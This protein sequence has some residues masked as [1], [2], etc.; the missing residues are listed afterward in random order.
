LA[1]APV[2]ALRR[3]GGIG[4][5]VATYFVGKE[6]FHARVGLL[7]AVILATSARV[8]W[9]SRWAHLDMPLSLFVT[10]ALLFFWRGMT[11][12]GSGRPFY[13]A[14]AF[15]A[16]ATLTKGLI[17]IVLPG[18]VLVA[19]VALRREWSSLLSWRIPSGALVFLAIA[20]PWFAWVSAQTE[21]RWL[22]E[23]IWVH[24]LER[25]TAS[26]GH[27]EPFYY[28]L[29][30]LPADFLPWSLFALPALWAYRSRLERLR[31]PGRLF[32]FLWAAVIFLFFS[33]SDSKRGLYLLPLFPPVAI[34][35]ACFFEELIERTLSLN[36]FGR[37]LALVFFGLL[38]VFAVASPVV[39]W[40]FARELFYLS[41]PL[42]ALLGAA[43]PFCALAVLRQK[44]A[45]LFYATAATTALA[46]L[47]VALWILPFADR[48]K[49][50]RRFAAIVRQNVAPHQPLYIYADG[51]HD[52]N[53][54]LE[55]ETIPVIAS[56]AELREL[57]ARTPDSYLLI[58]ER[59]LKRLEPLP[60]V[61]VAR[62]AIGGKSWYLVRPEGTSGGAPGRRN[63][64]A[65]FG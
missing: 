46:S 52:F 11:R 49:S 53:F 28:Y 54:Y 18:L 39:A 58:R 10:L 56:P 41:L 59:D 48:Y 50:P 32:L 22:A 19:F 13:L 42:A 31:Q 60:A 51:M 7:S 34:F 61:P 23:F 4:L 3:L 47:Y 65:G 26:R 8:V 16:L 36:R 62:G 17:G 27:E 21:G 57:V 43:S 44:P 24:H 14:Y 6:F 37:I 29:V 15:M 33:L 64:R 9:E 20:G 38:G 25:Y 40:L 2:F 45:R 30:N 1:G 5:V 63:D 35:T 12:P 55:R